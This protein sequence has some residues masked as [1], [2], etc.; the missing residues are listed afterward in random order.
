MEK[1]VQTFSKHFAV[2]HNKPL[3]LIGLKCLPYFSEFSEDNRF[4]SEELNIPLQIIDSEDDCRK[5]IDGKIFIKDV[6]KILE[7]VNEARYKA[8]VGK[9]KS[10][11]D[12]SSQRTICGKCQSPNP[13][14]ND[15]CQSC[16]SKLSN[17]CSYC[18]KQLSSGT[19]FCTNCGKKV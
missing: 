12:T 5:I 9:N 3:C 4:Y 18:H 11:S 13:S 2:I 17:L 6:K 15:F 16:G 8:P 14:D 7:V 19:K 1:F 10:T